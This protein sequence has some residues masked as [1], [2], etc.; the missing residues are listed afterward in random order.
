[1]TR[2]TTD[3]GNSKPRSIEIEAMIR[4]FLVTKQ[5]FKTEEL[6]NEAAIQIEEHWSKA[7]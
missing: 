1:M 4:L 6:L 7:T 5:Q 2:L 3:L